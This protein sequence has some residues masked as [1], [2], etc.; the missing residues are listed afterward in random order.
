[1]M[2][3]HQACGFQCNIQGNVSCDT[4]YNRTF[5][6]CFLLNH[7]ET[8]FPH[9]LCF[10]SNT[11]EFYL[12]LLFLGIVHWKNI[13]LWSNAPLFS[14]SLITDIIIIFSDQCFSANH[15][16]PLWSNIKLY[17]AVKAVLD[18]W[19]GANPVGVSYCWVHNRLDGVLRCP[20]TIR[21]FP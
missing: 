16:A 13:H 18:H 2:T 7:L 10:I 15:I 6:L 21:P 11:A 4:S 9:T 12:F 20:K 3:H 8:Y 5:C 1:M 19:F 14:V 17:W